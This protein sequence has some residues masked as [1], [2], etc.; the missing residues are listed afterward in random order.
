MRIVI[1][2]DSFKESVTAERAAAAIAHG[3]RTVAPGADCR[4]VPMSDGGEGFTDAIAAGLGADLIDVPTTDPLG[5]PITAR[6]AVAPARPSVG[7]TSADGTS[8]TAVL[9]IA[10][11]VGL[12][13]L[14]AGER[15]PRRATTRGL[16][17]LLR[18][19]A[20]RVQP[21]GRI[22][23]GLGG[24]ATN[25]AGMGMLV[26]LGLRLLDDTGADVDPV[27]E[28]LGRV[29]RVDATGLDPV[30][31]RVSIHAA[32]DVAN[33]LLGANGA[34][35]IFGPQK[36]AD[37][38]AV[39][40]LDAALAA[41]VR[42]AAGVELPGSEGR[43]I[44]P[45][46]ADEPGAGAAGGL[47]WALRAVL[48][49]EMTPGIELVADT[50][51]LD[52][53]VAGADLV[54]TGEGSVDA[55]TLAGKTPAGV[56]AAAQRHGVPCVVLAGRVQADAD[57]LH[58]HGVTALVPIVQ[59]VTDLEAALADGEANLERAAAMVMR[60]VTAR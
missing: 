20:R 35:A 38:Q 59:G 13:L 2:P 8:A 39:R 49:A 36:G 53:Q 50:V 16:G 30:L 32:C 48:G 1:A 29:V 57:V 55:Q 14:T 37:E 27:P 12:D 25:D 52:E 42:A 3:V 17:A 60:L 28:D 9:D 15:N 22:I 41:V 54:I 34:S 6:I 45:A 58:D 23:V 10:S 47:G 24:S 33:P 11:A 19:A 4:E 7:G 56:A 21:G 43:T 40:E 51:G 44:D 18:E 46:S 31:R 26:D 5:R